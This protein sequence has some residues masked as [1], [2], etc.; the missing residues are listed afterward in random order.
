MHQAI[1]RTPACR[2]CHSAGR[3]GAGRQLLPIACAERKINWITTLPRELSEPVLWR[4]ISHKRLM[5]AEAGDD[6]ERPECAM[7]ADDPDPD[8]NTAC[9]VVRKYRLLA[10]GKDVHFNRWR[11]LH[12]HFVNSAQ[13]NALGWVARMTDAERD[14]HDKMLERYRELLEE[15]NAMLVQVA[16]QSVAAEGHLRMVK[17]LHKEHGAELG[18]GWMW[19]MSLLQYCAGKGHIRVLSYLLENGCD[20]AI[21]ARSARSGIGAVDRACKSGHVCVLRLLIQHGAK[22]KD[23][24]RHNGETPAHGAAQYGHVDVLQ[25]LHRLGC[26]L[27]AQ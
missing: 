24:A 25:E 14:A 26:D 21:D 9:D 23:V 8:L 15:P 18:L 3:H 11:E 20:S 7:P 27:H 1:R 12:Q 5:L 22:Y 13:A 6:Y 4:W 17:K 16:L 19:G 2:P 10:Y